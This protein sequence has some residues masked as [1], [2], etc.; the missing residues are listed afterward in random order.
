MKLSPAGLFCQPALKKI[1]EIVVVKNANTTRALT[2]PMAD[3]AWNGVTQP[4]RIRLPQPMQ[5][6]CLNKGNIDRLNLP[7][8][9]CSEWATP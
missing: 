4:I 7:D 2:C 9:I 1:I 5:L 3:R 6:M 8:R